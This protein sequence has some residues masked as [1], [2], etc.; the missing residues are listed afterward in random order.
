M[1]FKKPTSNVNVFSHKFIG[2]LMPYDVLITRM[3]HINALSHNVEYLACCDATIM[4]NCNGHAHIFLGY[5]LYRKGYHDFQKEVQCCICNAH[6]FNDHLW[7]ANFG[8]LLNELNNTIMFER[9]KNEVLMH[10]W[11][12]ACQVPS[13]RP[14]VALIQSLLCES[15]CF[16]LL[17]FSLL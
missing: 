13:S 12:L 7:K 17:G 5:T 1:T 14:I 9:F 3:K 6:Y 10:K 16:V 2:Y 15:S 4:N 11:Q 8:I